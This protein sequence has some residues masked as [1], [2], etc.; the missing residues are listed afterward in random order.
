M[1]AERDAVLCENRL[2]G[3]DNFHKAVKIGLFLDLEAGNDDILV[4]DRLV[5]R[6]RFFNHLGKKLDRLRVRAADRKAVFLQPSRDL[7]GRMSEKSRKFHVAISLRR[8]DAKG[9]LQA[10]LC[11]IA[12]T[13]HLY[14]VCNLHKKSPFVRWI[15]VT[16]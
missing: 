8:N 4:T 11:R 13:V 10:L 5:V 15:T 2:C 9:L 16:S 12:Q 14:S 3:V 6:D 1:V 7:L